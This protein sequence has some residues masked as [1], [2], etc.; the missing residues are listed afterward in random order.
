VLIVFVSLFDL[1]RFGWK[2]EPFSPN[3]Y[4][5]PNTKV[6][7]YL[8]NQ[9]GLFRVMS[10]DARILPPN[11][12]IMYKLQTPDGYDPLYILRY[13]EL[14]AANGRN[15]ADISSP[16]GFYRIISLQNPDTRIIDLLGVK[17]VM[18]LEDLKLSKLSKVYSDASVNIY[19][20][21]N[22]LPRVFFVPST[23]VAK[24]KQAAIEAMFDL[25]YSY[26]KRAVVEGDIPKNFKE[27]WD[28]GAIKID[29]YKANYVKIK[30]SSKGDGFLVM[31]DAYYP[32]WK[33]KID[34]QETT[35]FITDFAFRGV[36]VPKGNHVIEFT[37]KLF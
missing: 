20:N 23:F 26:D 24:N 1:F 33:A 10:T 27:N 18:S 14:I 5:Y 28:I 11:F 32:T 34:G 17:Y 12:S 37:N 19:E 16:F 35:I 22:A 31:T 29:S 21:N 9:P 8:Q 4:L 2:F 30:T 25:N 6:T 15:N 13:G 7:T 3:K 36:V